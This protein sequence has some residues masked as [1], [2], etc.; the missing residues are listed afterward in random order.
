VIVPIKQHPEFK[1]L[2]AEV[3]QLS[4]ECRADLD[5]TLD[6]RFDEERTL[7]VEDIAGILDVH[8]VTVRRWIRAGELKA[9]R[10]RGYRVNPVDL[11]AFLQK[12][13][14]MDDT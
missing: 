5:A 14:T 10:I 13:R 1:A 9:T 11:S 7:T 4:P 2:A 3:R 6:G 8:V 12:R